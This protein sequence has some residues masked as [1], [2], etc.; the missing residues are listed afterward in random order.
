M[1]KAQIYYIPNV[2]S[3]ESMEEEQLGDNFSSHDFNSNTKKEAAD[4]VDV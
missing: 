1:N 3:Q 4:K 2:L